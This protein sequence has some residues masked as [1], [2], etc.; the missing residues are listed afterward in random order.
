MNSLTCLG[1]GPHESAGRRHRVKQ[2]RLVNSPGAWPP[3]STMP[4]VRGPASPA[5]LFELSMMRAVGLSWRLGKLVESLSASGDG[6]GRVP[7]TTV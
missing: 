5:E 6:V 7:S 4:I 2:G 1:R 3:D